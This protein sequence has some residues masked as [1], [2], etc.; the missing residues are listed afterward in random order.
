MRR[1]AVLRPIPGS[2]ASSVISVVDRAH[3]QTGDERQRG[4]L[5]HLGLQ[6]VGRPPLRLGDRRRHQVAEELGVVSFEDGRVDDD[7]HARC[8]GHRR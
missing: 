2:L 5:P 6:E 1:W 3:R 7:R 8:R 4:H